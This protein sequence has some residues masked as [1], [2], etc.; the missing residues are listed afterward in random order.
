[1]ILRLLGVGPLTEAFTGSEAPIPKISR[2]GRGA[3]TV[4]FALL[5]RLCLRP[6]IEFLTTHFRVGHL[7]L[8]NGDC[9][10]VTVACCG[11]GE[12]AAAP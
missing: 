6:M 2:G 11:R 10:I 5:G 4:R 9:G 12:L 7:R 8:L 1:M 3:P